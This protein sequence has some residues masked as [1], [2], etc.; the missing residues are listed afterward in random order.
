[1]NKK[2]L[3][4]ILVPLAVILWIVIV[5]KIVS[6]TKP[7]HSDDNIYL[8]G[9]VHLEDAGTVDTLSLLLNYPDPFNH[10][11]SNSSYVD[12]N[13]V[14]PRNI[15]SDFFARPPEIPLPDIAFKGV[16]ETDKNEKK[17]GLLIVN[18][19][20]VLVSETDTVAGLKIMDCWSDS[21]RLK[22]NG[23]MFTVKR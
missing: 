8:P 4:I 15:P 16:I 1:M 7:K 2:R 3:N 6:F 20:S 14:K 21:V 19:R 18:G 13:I 12:N 9:T 23:M 22:F 10:S 5:M 17:V 11:I